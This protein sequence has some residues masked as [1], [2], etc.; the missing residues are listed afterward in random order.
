MDDRMITSYQGRPFTGEIVD[1]DPNGTMIEL[2]TYA[3]GIEHGPQV[4]WFPDGTKQ[5]E[6][7]CDH[8]QAVG[9]WREWHPT[10]QLARYDEFNDLGDLLKRK[11]WDESG[12]LLED[13]SGKA[14]RKSSEPQ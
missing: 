12:E 13:Y 7:Q 11:R 1:F 5:L 6:G 2:T 8:G 14:P 4:E 9:E 10:G 3:D